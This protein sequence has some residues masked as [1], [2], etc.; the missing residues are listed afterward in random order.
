MTDKY[1]PISCDLHS[2]Y[3]LW[4]MRG[5]EIKLAWLDDD[6]VTHIERVKPVDVRAEMGNEY[7]YSSPGLCSI[8]SQDSVEICSLAHI[9]GIRVVSGS[10]RRFPAY[11]SFQ[12]D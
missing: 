11:G 3:E 9:V 2:Q 8:T 4:I 6:G 5:E 7:L 12:H 1:K 10:K